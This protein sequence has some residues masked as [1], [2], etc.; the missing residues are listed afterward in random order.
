MVREKIK[1]SF[2]F[3]RADG[4]IHGSAIDAASNERLAYCI[5]PDGAVHER[6]ESFPF[7]GWKYLNVADSDFIRNIIVRTRSLVPNYIA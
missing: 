7:R 5:A 1:F 3:T 4:T 6:N 2:L